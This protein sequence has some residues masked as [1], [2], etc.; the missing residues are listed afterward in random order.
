MFIFAIFAVGRPSKGHK[1]RRYRAFAPFR[2][3]DFSALLLGIA[4]PTPI[5]AGT[6]TRNP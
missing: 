1:R 5:R 6:T 3:P 4:K 2:A